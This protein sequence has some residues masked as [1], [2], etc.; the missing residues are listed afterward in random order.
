MY[1][2]TIMTLFGDPNESYYYLRR[3]LSDKSPL[4]LCSV[5]RGLAGGF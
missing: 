2:I 4:G 1:T 3:S 5:V